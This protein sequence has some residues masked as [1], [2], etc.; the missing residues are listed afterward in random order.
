MIKG[1]FHNKISAIKRNAI[2]D[3]TVIVLVYNVRSYPR[4]AEDSA[5]QQNNESR[6]RIYK[7]TK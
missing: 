3:D 4:L 6:Y 7:K 1:N 2:S 5:W